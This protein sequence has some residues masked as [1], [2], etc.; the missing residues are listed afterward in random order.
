MY[1]SLNEELEFELS[2]YQTHSI[3]VIIKM[4]GNIKNSWSLSIPPFLRYEEAL[5]CWEELVLAG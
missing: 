3:Y 2:S 4:K 1:T 5:W